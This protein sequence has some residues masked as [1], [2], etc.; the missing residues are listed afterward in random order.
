M[1]SVYVQ[2]TSY[3]ENNSNNNNNNNKTIKKY[4]ET[5]FKKSF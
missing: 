2:A 4:T 5:L 3:Y 1:L